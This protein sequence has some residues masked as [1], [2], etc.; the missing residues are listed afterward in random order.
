MFVRA[1]LLLK[2]TVPEMA[3]RHVVHY[4]WEDFDPVLLVYDRRRD[5]TERLELDR[6]DWS[7]S[8][9][10]WCVGSFG[11]D[12]YHP[13]AQARKVTK[14][15]QC[16]KCASSWIPVQACI[17]EPQCDGSRCES[18]ICK[19]EHTVYLAFFGSKAK[20]GM[21]T[22]RRLRERGIEQGADAI[23][24]LIRKENRLEGRRAENEI[25]RALRLPQMMQKRK[26][27]EEQGRN[28]KC[29]RLDEIYHSYLATLSSRMDVLDAK[30]EVLDQYPLKDLGG[31][32]PQLVDTA[33]KH[34]GRVL[35][36]KGKFLFYEDHLSKL[37]ALELADLPGRRLGGPAKRY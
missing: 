22:S 10:K 3:G 16:S 27:L 17:Y 2:D 15:D 7:L 30:L 4:G 23:V 36:S 6:L 12:G 5:K 33:G 25:S 20:I 19:R 14:F 8:E 31:R 32:V 21:T 24:P 11:E 13:C 1:D 37:N 9:A 34:R 28:V 26:V 18:R 35:G 29:G